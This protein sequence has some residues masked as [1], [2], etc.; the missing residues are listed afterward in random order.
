VLNGRPLGETK[1]FAS[2][3]RLIWRDSTRTGAIPLIEKNREL[4]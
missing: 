2:G 4:I 1:L 3:L